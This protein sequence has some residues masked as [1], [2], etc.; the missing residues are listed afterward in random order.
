MNADCADLKHKELTPKIKQRLKRFF[1]LAFIC[2]DL[3]P[4]QK[5]ITN[6]NRDIMTK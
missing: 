3:R 6:I 5:D 1:N 4:F 2:E